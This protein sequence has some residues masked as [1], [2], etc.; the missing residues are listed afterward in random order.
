[1]SVTFLNHLSCKCCQPVL[2]LKL[3]YPSH[4]VGSTAPR[5]AT[6][7]IRHY[8]KV[9][10]KYPSFNSFICQCFHPILNTFDLLSMDGNMSKKING[11]CYR[12]TPTN[13]KHKVRDKV[14]TFFVLSKL[15]MHAQDIL[16]KK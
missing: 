3:S 2:K 9:L 12:T 5:L 11:G 8:R 10:C 1:M 14:Q 15:C 13:P 16:Q 4:I 6:N 7:I